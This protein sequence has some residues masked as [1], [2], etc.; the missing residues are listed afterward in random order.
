MADRAGTPVLAKV[1]HV[2]GMASGIVRAGRLDIEVLS[3]GEEPPRE[4]HGYG[5]GFVADVGLDEAIEQLRR[6]GV[7]TSPAPRIT[8]GDGKQR[9]AWRATQLQDL[10]PD[11]FPAPFSTR[12]PGLIDRAIEAGS[13]ALSR[14]PAVARAATRRAGASMVVVTEYSFDVERWRATVEPGPAVVAVDIGTAG[15]RATWERLPLA[16]G[17]DLRLHD[18]GPAG[19]RR[20]VLTGAGEPFSAGDVAFEFAA[21]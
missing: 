9:R 21:G 14:I 12:R 2:R 1:E 13:G 20:V 5:A 19:I 16:N 4:P 10:L 8:A 11:P 6:I 3:L 17:L 7:G 18:D 15:H